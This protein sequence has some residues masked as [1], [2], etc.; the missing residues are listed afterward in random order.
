MF[1]AGWVAVA[2]QTERYLFREEHLLPS[3][4]MQPTTGMFTK[5]KGKRKHTQLTQRQYMLH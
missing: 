2:E 4:L 3:Q 5:Q 1:A